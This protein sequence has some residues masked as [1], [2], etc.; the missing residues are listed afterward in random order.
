MKTIYIQNTIEYIL[1]NGEENVELIEY[2]QTNAI[3]RDTD[4]GINY[5]MIEEE[6]NDVVDTQIN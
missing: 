4:G 1:K 6:N 5:M 2:L 3:M